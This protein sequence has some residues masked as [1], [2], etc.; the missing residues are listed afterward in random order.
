MLARLFCGNICLALDRG[1]HGK[2]LDELSTSARDAIE[3]LRA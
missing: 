2:R 1:L 3:Q